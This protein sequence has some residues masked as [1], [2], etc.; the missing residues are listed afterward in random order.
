MVSGKS[1]PWLKWKSLG[2]GLCSCHQLSSDF[3]FLWGH[4]QVEGRV[5]LK[6]GLWPQSRS[7]CS[8]PH[9]I[10]P[11]FIAPLPGPPHLAPAL[12]SLPIAGEEPHG[13]LPWCLGLLHAGASRDARGC[14]SESMGSVPSLVPVGHRCG[15]MRG[16]WCVRCHELLYWLSR[17]WPTN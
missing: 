6:S 17:D 7:L 10:V 1:H 12:L 14:G 16:G 13:S 8:A 11:R 9:S 15:W 3:K 4:T 5:G 2:S